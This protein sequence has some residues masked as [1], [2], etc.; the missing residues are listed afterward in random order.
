M[1]DLA[2]VINQ[3]MSNPESMRQ[4]QEMAASL[5]L[6]GTESPPPAPVQ[7]QAPVPV[8]GGNTPDLSALSSLLGGGGS[9]APPAQAAAPDLSKIAALF[10]LPMNQQPQAP[11]SNMP[12]LSSISGMLGGLMNSAPPKQ[13]AQGPDLSALTA[14]LSGQNASAPRTGG[15]PNIDLSTI[16]KLSGA[17]SSVQQ[18][19]ANIDL[20]FALKPRLKAERAKKVDDAVRIMQL[21]QFLPLIK[22]SGLFGEMDNILGG[23]GGGLGNLL[24]G[25][26]GGLF[27]SGRR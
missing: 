26:L 19:R 21:I 4:I 24:G 17:L 13:D 10:G 3:V 1:D 14:L 22:E 11:Q 25:G 8:S 23:L 6:T 20:L 12:D 2:S 7:T 18:N 27:G 16:T 15:L 9:P 5:G